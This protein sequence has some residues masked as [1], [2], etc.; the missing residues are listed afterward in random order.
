[1]DGLTDR[2][3]CPPVLW[4]RYVGVRHSGQM[5]P[6]SR[7]SLSKDLLQPQSWISALL[8]QMMLEEETL[9]FEHARNCLGRLELLIEFI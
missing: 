1:M 3:V 5:L 2:A 4:V 7:T 8:N 6:P 9:N